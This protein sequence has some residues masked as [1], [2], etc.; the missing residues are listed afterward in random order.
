MK[1]P[2]LSDVI[3]HRR[4]RLKLWIDTHFSGSQASFIDDASKRTEEPINQGE[5]SSLIGG[6]KSFGEKKARKLETQGG[7]PFMWLDEDDSPPPEPTD[8]D[9]EFVSHLSGSAGCGNGR[10][11]E[12]TTVKGGLAFQRSFLKSLG[13]CAE[14]ARVITSDGDSMSPTIKDKVAVLINTIDKNLVSG[15]VYALLDHNGECIIKRLVREFYPLTNKIEWIIRSD[16]LD[17]VSYPDKVFPQD[18]SY[19]VVGRAKWNDNRL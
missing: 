1:K 11:N 14:S 18:D 5:L 8:D 17:K 15:G 16:N 19:A 13:V 12:H 6:N 2:S 3:E 4:V 9:F 7:M 10:F